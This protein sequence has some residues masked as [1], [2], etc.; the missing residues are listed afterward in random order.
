M[1]EI[2]CQSCSLGLGLTTDQYIIQ[3]LLSSIVTI[4]IPMYKPGC[5]ESI[6]K[7]NDGINPGEKIRDGC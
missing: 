2:T 7:C 6:R 4:V 5:I 1:R 3:L